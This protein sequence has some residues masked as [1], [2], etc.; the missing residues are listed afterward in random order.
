[1][2]KN[3]VKVNF[4]IFFKAVYTAYNAVEDSFNRNCEEV[5]ADRALYWGL[6]GED[7]NL[8]DAAHEAATRVY[9]ALGLVIP[10]MEGMGIPSEKIDEVAHSMGNLWSATAMRWHKRAMEEAIALDEVLTDL[11]G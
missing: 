9:E 7:E 4:N 10:A 3:M 2:K 11:F 5:L 1:M 6:H 8:S